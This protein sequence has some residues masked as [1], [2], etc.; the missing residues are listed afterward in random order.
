MNVA[1]FNFSHGDH[2]THG[3]CLARLREAVAQ[4]PGCHVAVMLDTKG[5]VYCDFLIF[6]FFFF[7]FDLYVNESTITVLS[8]YQ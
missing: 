1:R 3:A 7:F 4:R 5:I 2:E 6:F 8:Y